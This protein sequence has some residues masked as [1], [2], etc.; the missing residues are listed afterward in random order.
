MPVSPELRQ[1]ITTFFVQ[2]FGISE[3]FIANLTMEANKEEIWA[4]TGMVLPGIFSPRA[5][6]LRIGRDF[7]GGFKPTS[8]FLTALGSLITRSVIDVSLEELRSLL[9]GQRI[10]YAGAEV[11]YVALSYQGDVLGCGQCRND[12]LHALIPTGR[13]QELLEILS[14]RS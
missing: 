1:Q 3:S 14:I 9:L 4:G 10:P 11:G 8:V 5:I 12:K 2:Q 6:G 7:S 13:R